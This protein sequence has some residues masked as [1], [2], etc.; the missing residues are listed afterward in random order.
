MVMWDIPNGIYPIFSKFK[1]F[2][3]GWL[4][5]W[6]CCLYEYLVVGLASRKKVR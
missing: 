4:M 2:W 5:A 1:R 3:D 6:V